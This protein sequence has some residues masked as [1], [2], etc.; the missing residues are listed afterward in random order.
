MK[1]I[2]LFTICIMQVFYLYSQKR[3]V[4]R[5]FSMQAEND[6]FMA[7]INNEDK[8]YSGG[9]RF[10][11]YTDYLR[12]GIFPLFRNREEDLSEFSLENRLNSNSI[13]IHGLGFTPNRDSFVLSTPVRSQR[14]F[15]SVM[16]V[17]WKRN[18][19]FY[20]LPFNNTS[21][22]NT[23][24][25][26]DIFIGKIG[27]KAPGNVQNFLH[28]YVT[29][30][31]FVNGWQNQI[32]NGGK[33]VFTYKVAS[34][35]QMPKRNAHLAVP[36]FFVSPEISLGNLFING[37]LRLSLSNQKISTIG[38]VGAMQSA[39]SN[40]LLKNESKPLYHDY[41]TNKG[42]FNYEV[43]VRTI[44][45]AHNSTLQGLPFYDKSVHKIGVADLNRFVHDVGFK[46]IAHYRPDKIK[47]KAL[48][49]NMVFLEFIARSKEFKFGRSHFYGNLGFVIMSNR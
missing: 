9:F 23:A 29:E 36:S 2:L 28:E 35:F 18:A 49:N 6:V 42:W 32:A 20:G 37:G 25:V 10:E 47:E 15:S 39:K 26:S 5:G 13:Y 31:D 45:V 30:S 48:R 3:K 44:Y 21:K 17:G 7:W 8:D 33:W 11:F 12:Q 46:F 40:D 16:G 22:V 4:I 43:Y 34:Y 14:P 1:K 24:I 41:G 27:V 38:Q 19:V